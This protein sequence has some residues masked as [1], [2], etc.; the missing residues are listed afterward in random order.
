MAFD[1]K[2]L[3]PRLSRVMVDGGP[4][5]APLSTLRS[6]DAHVH[7]ELAIVVDG[8]R[9]PSLGFFG[10]RDV[11][12]GQWLRVLTKARRTLVAGD[13]ASYLFDEGEQG[14][15]A[16]RFQR[17]GDRVDV[18]IVDSAISDGEGDPVWG[19]KSCTFAAFAAGIAA[20]LAELASALEEAAP[21]VGR[22]W[23]SGALA[24]GR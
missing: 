8:G 1:V 9:L 15:P 7:G 23:V 20:F 11:C 24:R 19:T 10:P 21:G 17:V 6:T 5:E 14:Q 18:S 2:L 13:S 22:E 4:K 16:F 12:I 3:E